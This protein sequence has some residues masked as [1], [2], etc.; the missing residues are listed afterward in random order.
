MKNKLNSFAQNGIAVGWS[1][2]AGLILFILICFSQ[3]V[4]Y[5]GKKV[6]AL[7]YWAI[8]LIGIALVTVGLLLYLRCQ[9]KVDHFTARLPRYTILILTGVLFL[10]QL[11][12]FYNIFFETGWDSGYVVSIARRI[13]AGDSG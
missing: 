2:F 6:F 13:G 7:P 3:S 9:E 1:V 11:V 10:V 4:S 12:I 8:L 5:K